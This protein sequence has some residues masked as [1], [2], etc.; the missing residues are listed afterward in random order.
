MSIDPYTAKVLHWCGRWRLELQDELRRL[1]AGKIIIHD[2]SS[3]QL[4]EATDETKKRIRQRLAELDALLKS[5][6]S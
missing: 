2:R 4:V 3:G 6:S 1:Q 5:D